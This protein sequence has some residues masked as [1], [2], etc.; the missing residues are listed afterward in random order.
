MIKFSSLDLKTFLKMQASVIENGTTFLFVNF[1]MLRY[2]CYSF[3]LYLSNV[4][5]TPR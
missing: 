4:V 3:E 2:N 5:V 1:F